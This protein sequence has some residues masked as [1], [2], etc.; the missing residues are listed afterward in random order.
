VR[1]G[2]E[3]LALDDP[4]DAE[5]W[6]SAMMGTF[7]KIDAPFEAR[8]ELDA[9][10]WPEVVRRA[11]ARADAEGLAVLE[12][13][14]AVAD[15][16]LATDVR[17]AAVRL[18][19]AGIAAP[20]WAADLGTAT[21]EGAWMLVDV[22]GDHEAY[23]ATF[24]YPG[25]PAHLVNALYDKARGEII[26]DGF[27]GYS[28]DDPRQLIPKEDGVSTA[29]AD[30]AAMARRILDAIDSG[31]TYIDNDWTPEFKRFRAIILARMR[32]LPLAP[33]IEPPEP[34]DD[35]ARE[36]IVSEFLASGAVSDHDEADMVV[37]HCLDYLCDYLGEDPFRWSPI[38][39]EQFLLDYLPRK[40]S[41][42]LGT[43]AQ[44]PAV[45]RAWV[46]FAL[47]KRGL[48]ERWIVET[49][50]A[51]GR[52]ANEFRRAITDSKHF[53]PAKLLG[54]AILADGV[55]PLDQ[56]AVDEWIREFNARPLSE[57]DKFLGRL[58][59]PR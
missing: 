1:G 34:P 16:A 23:F 29:D 4:L 13:L 35:A 5:A 37:S 46:R 18:R 10:L 56:A 36:A 2:R 39:V 54:N 32:A 22:F 49:Q 38:V 45:L 12:A 57:R 11:E 9:R 53:G 28:R 17:A 51:V 21:F 40:V 14:S 48:E 3:L 7:Y 50:R 55:D 58:D 26:S 42:G 30:P 31:D 25:R 52:L 44:L 33:P 27:V 24:R 20:S 47:T 41:L 19:S 59:R 43:V 8:E 15:A 6:A